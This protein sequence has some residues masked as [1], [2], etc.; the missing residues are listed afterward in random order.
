[1]CEPVCMADKGEVAVFVPV[2]IEAQPH[3]TLDIRPDKGPF[4]RIIGAAWF[5]KQPGR[6]RL[7]MVD[8]RLR[9]GYG[10]QAVGHFM[11]LVQLLKTWKN[12][13]RTD[14]Q[15]QSNK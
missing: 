13:Q 4:A 11:D 6:R 3:G 7:R 1:M 5:V 8:Q 15:D 10:L 9:P 14:K 12:Q 2:N